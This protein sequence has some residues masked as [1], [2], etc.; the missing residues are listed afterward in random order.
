MVNIEP[1]YVGKY[2]AMDK[3]IDDWI[4]RIRGEVET[5]CPAI[6]GL[7]V[8]KMLD[9]LYASAEAGKEVPIE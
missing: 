8:Q 3:K 4:G 2:Q 9:G 7:K 6:A 1:H 5:Q